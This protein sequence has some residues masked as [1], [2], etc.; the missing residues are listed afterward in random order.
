M[1]TEWEAEAAADDDTS[2]LVFAAGILA[3]AG[4]ALY[5][6]K[7]LTNG[8]YTV[9]SPPVREPL[10]YASPESSVGI[11]HYRQL[12]RSSSNFARSSTSAS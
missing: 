3:M 4:V 7:R 8:D 1:R 12:A 9:N 11:T 10:L 5:V 6:T 2:L